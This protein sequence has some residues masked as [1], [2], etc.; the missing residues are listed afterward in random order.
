MSS[1]DIMLYLHIKTDA[2]YFFFC[3]LNIYRL[4]AVW[5][6]RT[7]K[8]FPEVLEAPETEGRGTLLRPR[9][10]IFQYGPTW[11]VNN[12]F[13]FSTFASLNSR[14]KNS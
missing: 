7:E 5:E 8:Y 13:I 6:V 14:K 10:N 2:S 1:T 11:T 12:L 3:L 9:E 4:F